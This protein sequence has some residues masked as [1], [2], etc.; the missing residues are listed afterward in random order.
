[1]INGVCVCVNTMSQDV[2]IERTEKTE[3]NIYREKTRKKIPRVIRMM[4]YR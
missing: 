2:Y 3:I 4:L 1:M